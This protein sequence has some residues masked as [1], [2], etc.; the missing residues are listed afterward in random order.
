MSP[1]RSTLFSKIFRR[2]FLR[3]TR[4]DV[5]PLEKIEK[6]T[7]K[8]REYLLRRERLVQIGEMMAEVVH[9]L[10]N[11][12]TSIVGFSD[13]LENSSDPLEMKEYAAT[14]R[15]EAGRCKRIA[16]NLLNFSRREAQCKKLFD[17][18]ELISDVLD[19]KTRS[20]QNG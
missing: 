8:T 14:I 10:N 2:F 19:L 16:G 11:P 9:E 12:L 6:A 5:R 4:P 17:P 13:L 18:N 7:G 3:F 1:F 15:K 20:L